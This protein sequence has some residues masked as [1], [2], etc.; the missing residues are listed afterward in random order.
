MPI[1]IYPNRV[2][3]LLVIA[4]AALSNSTASAAPT[5]GAEVPKQGIIAVADLAMCTAIYGI[6]FEQRITPDELRE[7]LLDAEMA[8]VTGGILVYGGVKLTEGLLAEALN[9]LGPHAWG[10]SGAITVTVTSL[11]GLTFWRCCET[12]PEWLTA[13]RNTTP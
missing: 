1:S 6:W 3:T 12:S 4:G 2:K 11:V 8:T 10:I 13:S 9:L 7:I 5:V